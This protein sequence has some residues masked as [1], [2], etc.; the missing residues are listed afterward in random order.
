MKRKNTCS[1]TRNKHI[2]HRK[3]T[4]ESLQK[5]ETQKAIVCNFDMPTDKF[6]HHLI[7]QSKINKEIYG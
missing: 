2:I 3:P 6:L 7:A 4:P 1:Q 5:L